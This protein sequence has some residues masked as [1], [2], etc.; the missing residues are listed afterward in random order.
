MRTTKSQTKYWKHRKLD[1]KK[2]YFDTW[3]E[4]HRQFIMT[5]LGG[6]Q[7]MSLMEIGVGGGANLAAITRHLKGKQI[8]GIDINEDAI[9]F[10]EKTFDNGMFKVCPADDIMM[11]DKSADVL[12][13]DMTYIYVGPTKINNCLKEL[14]RTARKE[15]V[16]HEYYIKNPFKRLWM[17]L[18]H[19]YFFYDYPK[20]LKKLDFYDIYVIKVPGGGDDLQ[21]KHRYLIKAKP[22]QRY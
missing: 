13:S 1:W 2:E 15:I 3:N 4:P 7:W 14:R 8:G 18:K 10:C 6:F 11:S 17:Y 20:L 22:P 12:L 5:V 16:I 19:G 21:R 9:D